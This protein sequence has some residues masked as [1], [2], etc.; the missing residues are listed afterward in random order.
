MKTARILLT[1]RGPWLGRLHLPARPPSL[2]PSYSPGD[3]HAH[4]SDDGA[5]G[6]HPRYG[7]DHRRLLLERIAGPPMPRVAHLATAKH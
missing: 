7:G 2:R 4:H 5:G 3:K 6:C 1:R